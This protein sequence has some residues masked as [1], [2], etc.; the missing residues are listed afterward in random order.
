MCLKV[1]R[2]MPVQKATK[3]IECYKVLRR[4]DNNILQTPYFNQRVEIGSTCESIILKHGSR[5][6]EGLHSIATLEDA[7][8]EFHEWEDWN[9][10]M[11]VIALCSIQKEIVTMKELL[12]VMISKMPVRTPVVNSSISN[13]LIQFN[14]F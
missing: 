3:A 1:E 2:L 5:V 9:K 10:G 7:K 13:C 14:I 11:Y 6:F 8:K 4:L 12:M